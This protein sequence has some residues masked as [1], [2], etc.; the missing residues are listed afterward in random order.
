MNECRHTERSIQEEAAFLLEMSR[1]GLEPNRAARARLAQW[2]RRSPEHLEAY[3]RQLTVETELQG[4]DQLRDFDVA[5]LVR[6][7]REGINVVRWPG[8]VPGDAKHDRPAAKDGDGRNAEV[9]S[10]L[11]RA[12]HWLALAA[13]CSMVA[14]IPGTDPV[15]RRSMYQI[16]PPSVVHATGIG[17][18]RRIELP[19]GSTCELNTQSEIRLA[20]S[21][22]QREVYLVAGEALF[23]VRHDPRRPFRVH[24]GQ[25]QIQDIGTQFNIRRSAEVTIVSV[26]EGEVQISRSPIADHSGQPAKEQPGHSLA[27]VASKDYRPLQGQTLL[28]AGEEMKIVADGSLGRRGKVDMHQAT[29]WLDGRLVFSEAT[30][31]QVVAEFNRYNE[32]QI[33]LIGETRRPRLFS[34]AF[35][36]HDPQS[37]LEYLRT[38]DKDLTIESDTGR[39]VI[40]GP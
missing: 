3:L 28:G 27:V 25:T 23:T 10:P 36:A 7:G 39:L 40:R 14:L 17:E 13:V 18:H 16:T 1:G 29:A 35:D 5:E 19:D 20:F 8:T 12:T 4:L 6:R 38:D 22:G 2:V 34:G 37:F 24:A 30:L 26:M 15:S 33:I 31:E 32:Q 9:V 11:K 21:A